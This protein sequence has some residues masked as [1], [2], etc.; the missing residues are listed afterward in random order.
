MRVK[1]GAGYAAGYAAGVV[2]GG[3]AWSKAYDKAFT[4]YSTQN[5]KVTPGYDTHWTGRATTRADTM[6]I[7]SAGV[8]VAPTDGTN[9]TAGAGSWD[10]PY[11]EAAI[12]DLLGFTPDRRDWLALILLCS[13]SSEANPEANE[14][15]DI[16]LNYGSG[17]TN[18]NNN[19]VEQRSNFGTRF[20]GGTGTHVGYVRTSGGTQVGASSVDTA[21]S[22]KTLLELQIRGGQVFGFYGRGAMPT[23][24]GTLTAFTA[25]T[26][27]PL[28]PKGPDSTA[29]AFDPVS[30]V[31]ALSAY[32]QGSARTVRF[33]RL[34]IW[35]VDIAGVGL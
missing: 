13:L 5:L 25:D 22:F 31:V 26:D 1:A 10:A 27:F 2:A 11:V 3:L 33:E 28:D 7:G 14:L 4:T 30:D 15:L 16:Q 29:R 6:S 32:S 24:P 35:H 8:S 17:H 34:A 18:L 23:A 20:V 12:A 19:R 21:A 9:W